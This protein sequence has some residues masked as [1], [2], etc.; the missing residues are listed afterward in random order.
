MTTCAVNPAKE[1]ELFLQTL[2]IL[3]SSPSSKGQLGRM[4]QVFDH[5]RGWIDAFKFEINEPL[6]TLST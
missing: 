2:T 5:W 1:L 6:Q 3:M 4:E